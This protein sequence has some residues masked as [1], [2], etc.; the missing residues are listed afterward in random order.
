LTAPSGVQAVIEAVAAEARLPRAYVIPRKIFDAY[1]ATAALQRGVADFTG[2]Q[3]DAAHR[4]DSRWVLD[5]SCGEVTARQRRQITTEFLIGADGAASRVR[6][7]L[8]LPLNSE[9]HTLIAIRAYATTRTPI[10]PLIQLD[11]IDLDIWPGYG[12]VFSYGPHSVNVGIGT[13]VPSYKAKQR[14]LPDLLASY[15]SCLGEDFTV[16]EATAQ[17]APLPHAGQ[18]PHLAFPKQSA[19][20]IG[21][22]ASMINPTSGEGIAYGMTAGLLLGRALADAATHGHDFAAA[23]MRYEREF[24][25]HFNGHLRSNLVIGKIARYRPV[26]ERLIRCY[27]RSN[28]DFRDALGVLWGNLEHR[29]SLT[30]SLLLLAR[31]L[32]PSSSKATKLPSK[33]RLLGIS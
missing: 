19:A 3:L 21:Y 6:R 22:A 28:D 31:L 2:W 9:K 17:S 10:E 4:H 24:K 11:M 23:A 26:V 32:A 16:D 14:R 29:T 27:S 12:W 33:R 1:L 8:G 20:L 13:E 30:H 7:S 25:T 5:L 15:C 18:M